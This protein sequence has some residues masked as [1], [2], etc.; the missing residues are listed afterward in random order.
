MKYVVDT[1]L[2]RFDVYVDSVLKKSDMGFSEAV[3][4]VSKI[5]FFSGA[6][7]GSVYFDN[8]I[9]RTGGIVKQANN[10]VFETYDS[11]TTG[12][13]PASWTLDDTSGGTVK[14]AE[15]PSATDKSVLLN[16]TSATNAVIASRTFTATSGYVTVEFDV[17]PGQTGAFLD[18][19]S[20]F[21]SSGNRPVRAYFDHL[22]DT[23]K[24]TVAKIWIEADNLNDIIDCAYLICSEAIEKTG[25]KIDFEKFYLCDVY[26]Y[27]RYCTPLEK[28]QKI[29]LDYLLP[30]IKDVL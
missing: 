9:V 11:Q 24:G 26:T 10:R 17:K 30:V 22:S 8:V 14:I 21:D 23:F 6:P 12:L 28:G 1:D 29:V 2:S 4:S 7:A 15:Q 20:V 5:Q 27:D 19:G 13:A 3:L 25:Y 16:D 18:A